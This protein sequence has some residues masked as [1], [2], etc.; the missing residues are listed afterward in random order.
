MCGMDDG[1]GVANGVRL[2]ITEAAHHGDERTVLMGVLQ[3]QRDLVSWK[4]RDAPDDVLLA[5]RSG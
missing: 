3:R 4:R 5:V 1:T 2:G